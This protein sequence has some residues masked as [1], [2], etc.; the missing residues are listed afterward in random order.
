[1]TISQLIREQ[2]HNG[3]KV[4]DTFIGED[5][6]GHSITK[7]NFTLMKTEDGKACIIKSFTNIIKH[8]Q[9]I[10][11]D[12]LEVSEMTLESA[13]AFMRRAPEKLNCFYY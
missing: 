11:S 2:E 1:M 3:Y 4:I 8:N 6:E 12:I 9:K 10:D 5:R 13:E 7:H